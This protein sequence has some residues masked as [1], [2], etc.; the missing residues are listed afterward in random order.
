MKRCSPLCIANWFVKPTASAEAEMPQTLKVS[1]IGVQNTYALL[2]GSHDI[3][4]T[5]AQYLS[6]WTFEGST[7]FRAL[8][9]TQE[10]LLPS[11]HL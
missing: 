4:K 1:M 9:K 6:I 3:F 2:F 11:R 8:L 5:W 10:F 7:V